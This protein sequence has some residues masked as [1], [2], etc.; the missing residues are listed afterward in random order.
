MVIIKLR[1]EK[2]DTAIFN[3]NVL[4]LEEF[5][6][7]LD[8]EKEEREYLA[9]YDPY[10]V[11]VKIPVENLQAI[12]FLEKMGFNFVELQIREKISLK[13]TFD[14][15]SKQYS[16]KL[17][18]ST[19]DLEKVLAI[20]GTTFTD[21]RF[22]I[23][24]LLDPKIS[25]ARYELFVKQSYEEKDQR[26]YGLI[27]NKTL[28][29]L[30]F[31]THK[32]LDSS[33]AMLFLGGIHT[34]YKSLGLG[35]ILALLELNELKRNGIKKVYTHISARNYNVMNLELTKIGFKVDTSY[36][37][38]RKIYEKKLCLR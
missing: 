5:S 10:Y 22:R 36:V 38:L 2:H 11:S 23:D 29:I 17:I 16:L 15:P 12:H 32:Y 8:F 27:N 20:A 14:I 4:T 33:K 25:T 13:K 9:K 37:V 18:Q 7:D 35:I 3:R 30:G 34:K 24:P 6:L 31:K 26:V 21:D 19:S 28:E 1:I